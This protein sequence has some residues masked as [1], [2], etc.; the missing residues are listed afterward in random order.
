MYVCLYVYICLNMYVYVYEGVCMYV[1]MYVFEVVCICVSMVV[2]ICLCCTYTYVYIYSNRH[3]YL[4]DLNHHHVCHVNENQ[5]GFTALMKASQYGHKD[6]AKLLTD[7][8]ADLNLQSN[9]SVPFY[10]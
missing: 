10:V 8:G 6:I 2:F 1:C 4:F 9:V 7:K 5:D 3:M